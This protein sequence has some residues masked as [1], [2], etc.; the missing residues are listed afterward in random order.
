MQDFNQ[1]RK[2]RNLRKYCNDEGI[3]Y[4]WLSEY[5]HTYGA[6]KT[7]VSSTP[8]PGVSDYGFIALDVIEERLSPEQQH[9]QKDKEM[10]RFH[11]ITREQAMFLLS[12]A[13]QSEMYI[14]DND[15]KRTGRGFE[16]YMEYVRDLD[17][18]QSHKGIW[19]WSTKTIMNELWKQK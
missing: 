11:H 12:N 13:V 2:D 19:E 8:A 10:K 3:D 18:D 6:T 1:N 14:Y 7:A 5:K 4:K 16:R 15:D 9:P 17:E